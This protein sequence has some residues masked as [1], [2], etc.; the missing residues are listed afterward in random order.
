MDEYDDWSPLEETD[1]PHI[2]LRRRVCVS[3]RSY[4]VS[5]CGG[6]YEPVA[7]RLT[8]RNAGG[9][10]VTDLRGDVLPQDLIDVAELLQVTL[11]GVATATRRDGAWQPRGDPDVPARPGV[12]P[13]PGVEL[14]PNAGAK[15]TDED[16]ARLVERHRAGATVTELMAEFGRTDGGIRSRLQMLGESLSTQWERPQRLDDLS[17]V[18]GEDTAVADKAAGVV[19]D[20]ARATAHGGT[21]VADHGVAAA[22]HGPV[23]GGVDRAGPEAADDRAGAAE[24]AGPID[25]EA[26]R[27]RF[28]LSAERDRF[29][30]EAD[31]DYPDGFDSHLERVA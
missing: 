16:L 18:D 11:E 24:G 13:P 25:D 20:G 7:V 2:D 14:P 17:E 27:E 4:E 9:F 31:L 23:V 19:G 3:G 5:A 22:D 15:W 21:T 26:E 6:G 1:P 12:W 29:I 8:G 28:V 30:A 10:I